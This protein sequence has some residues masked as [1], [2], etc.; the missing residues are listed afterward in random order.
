MVNNILMESGSSETI[1]IFHMNRIQYISLTHTNKELA[2]EHKRKCKNSGNLYYGELNFDQ[3]VNIHDAGCTFGRIGAETDFVVIDIDNT[4]V[5]IDKVY[6]TLKN[7][8]KYHVSYSAS[9]NR[10]KYHIFV[11]LGY[12]VNVEEYPEVVNR[13]FMAVKTVVCGRMDVM[14]LDKNAANFYQC[15]FGN[16]V[17]QETTYIESVNDRQIVDW[18][19][20]GQEPLF[21]E[22]KTWRIPS[23]NTS[24][25]CHKNNQGAIE[26]PNRYDIIVP[27]MTKGR[28]KKIA[29]GHRFN[30]AKLL[31]CQLLM[32]IHYLNNVFGEEWTR[33]DY[34]NTWKMLVATNTYGD[35]TKEQNFKALELWVESQFNISLGNDYETNQRIYD[36]YFTNTKAHTYVSRQWKYETALEIINARLQDNIVYFESTTELNEIAKANHMSTQY[37]DAIIKKLGYSRKCMKRKGSEYDWMDNNTVEYIAKGLWSLGIKEVKNGM[38]ERVALMRRGYDIKEVNNAIKA[39]MAEPKNDLSETGKKLGFAINANGYVDLIN[40]DASLIN[41]EDK[42]L[43]K[44]V[45]NKA[46]SGNLNFISKLNLPEDEINRLKNQLEVKYKELSEVIEGVDVN[47]LF[48]VNDF[49]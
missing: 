36:S 29:V 32:R 38:K 2:K 3:V 21:K 30:W 31:A 44:D 25:W 42:G 8:S 37:I 5:D 18:C 41:V 23:L 46:Y 13:E 49:T 47:T 27:S 17:T 40:T 1:R 9:N 4:T 16:S 48:D 45:L 26:E 7:N 34:M 39:F 12:T 6:E 24:D 11:D 10:N 33:E 22:Q 15:F 35:F 20:K 43:A 28:M 19:H 14:E